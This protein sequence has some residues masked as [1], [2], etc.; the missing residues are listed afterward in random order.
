MRNFRMAK[1]RA[2]NV[3]PAITSRSQLGVL[4]SAK[5]NSTLAITPAHNAGHHPSRYAHKERPIGVKIPTRILSRT[6]DVSFF[7]KSSAPL[8]YRNCER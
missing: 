2:R 8:A 6:S 4:V 1:S 3:H 7:S 5:K